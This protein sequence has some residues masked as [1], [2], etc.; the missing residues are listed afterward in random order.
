M[1]GTLSK[2]KSEGGEFIT[3]IGLTM[4]TEFRIALNSIDGVGLFVGTIP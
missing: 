4:Y 3:L 2:D 1:T